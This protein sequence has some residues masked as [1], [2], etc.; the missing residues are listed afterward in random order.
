MHLSCLAE[1]DSTLCTARPLYDIGQIIRCGRRIQSVL[2]KR[3]H[4]WKSFTS[5]SSIEDPSYIYL[6]FLF[7]THVPHPAASGVCHF[8]LALPLLEDCT[9]QDGDRVGT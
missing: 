8:N 7:S 5:E 3:S 2:Q 6:I 9:G 1:R 4:F